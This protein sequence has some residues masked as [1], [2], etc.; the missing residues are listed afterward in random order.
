M[1]VQ[2]PR[3]QPLEL[4]R[5]RLVCD[6]SPHGRILRSAGTAL[7]LLNDLRTLPLDEVRD[8]HLYECR[9][10]FEALWH[11]LERCRLI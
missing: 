2:I 10:S 6:A 7:R 11:E 3:A 9:H 4:P 1:R 5:A 8:H